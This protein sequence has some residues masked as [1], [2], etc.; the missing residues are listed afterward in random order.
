M[1]YDAKYI[2]NSALQKLQ[3][4]HASCTLAVAKE[5]NYGWVQK[6]VNALMISGRFNLLMIIGNRINSLYGV[7]F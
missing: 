6:K 3:E 5:C 7:N 2:C 4:V 1:V